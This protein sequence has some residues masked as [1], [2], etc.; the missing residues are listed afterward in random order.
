MP[1]EIGASQRT[2][3]ELISR[4]A[5]D[6][7]VS[8]LQEYYE[9]VKREGLAARVRAPSIVQDP[10]ASGYRCPLSGTGRSGGGRAGAGGADR[11]E[12]HYLYRAEHRTPDMA[13]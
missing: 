8:R 7:R 4:L 10:N 3:S 6:F 13:S 5:S 11:F 2:E 12:T 1:C 9:V